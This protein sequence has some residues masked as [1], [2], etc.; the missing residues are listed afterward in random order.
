MD[1]DNVYTWESL[2]WQ[3]MLHSQEGDYWC[4]SIGKEI[5]GGGFDHVASTELKAQTLSLVCHQFSHKWLA[6]RKTAPL[7]S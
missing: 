3:G 7:Y 1:V 2:E 5:C 4:P 6:Q